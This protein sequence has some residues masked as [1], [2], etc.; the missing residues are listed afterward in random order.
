MDVIL[1]PH[2]QYA[3]AYLDS[4]TVLSTTWAK[5]LYQLGAVLEELQKAGLIKNPCKCHLVLTKAQYLGYSIGRGLF[6]PLEKNVKAVR[7]YP[8]PTSKKQLYVF[9]VLV[10]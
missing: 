1:H 3:T 4:I 10:G 9:G 2:C 5:H 8:W 7:G 6:R